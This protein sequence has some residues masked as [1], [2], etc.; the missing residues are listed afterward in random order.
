[1]W[2]PEVMM[3]AP[4][5]E[6]SPRFLQLKPWAAFSIHNRASAELAFQFGQETVAQRPDFTTSPT[7][8]MLT[9]FTAAR[10][11]YRIIH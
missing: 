5:A 2:L 10:R 6:T 11:S 8:G 4:S 1:M 3:S 7:K 9:W